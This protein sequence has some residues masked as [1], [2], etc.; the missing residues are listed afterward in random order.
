M[1]KLTAF[2]LAAILLSTVLSAQDSGNNLSTSTPGTSG[3]I[4][5]HPEQGILPFNAPCTDCV[6]LL[7]KRTLNHREFV[8][9]SDGTGERSVFVQQSLGNMHY[10]DENGFL[11]TKDP[12]MKKESEF[13]YA[14]RQQPSPVV[15]D[16]KNK[17]A[18]I[19]NSDKELK[20]N[21]N[22]SLV[23]I[24]LTGETQNF[25][26]G[27]WS[28]VVMSDDHTET[29]LTVK[30]F[31]PGINLVMTAGAGRLKTSFV[32][33]QRLQINQ[34]FSGG[35]LAMTQQLDIPPGLTAD[36]SASI[37]N[38]EHRHL[39][40]L[41]LRDE[42]NNSAFYFTRST[43]YDARESAENFLEMPF[44]FDDRKIEYYVPVNWLNS[45]LTKYPVT[46]DPSVFSGDT[47]LQASIQSSGYSA[48]CGTQGCSYAMN[49]VMVP[50]G[51]TYRIFSYFAYLASLP[52]TRQEG[53]FEITVTNP[54]TGSTCSTGNCS[55]LGSVQGSCAFWPQQL[56]YFGGGSVAPCLSP[57]CSS[58][59]LNFEILLRRCNWVPVPV[60]D[61]TCIQAFTD[62]II[63]IESS[64]AIDISAPP[65]ICSGSCTDI[66]AY[67]LLGVP[68]FTYSWNGGT[69]NGSL[70]N[71]CPTTT[72]TYECIATDICGVNDTD[73]VSIIVVP[74]QNPGFTIGPSDS[75]CAGTQMTFTAN[76]NDPDSLFSWYVE[77]LT[78]DTITDTKVVNYTAPNNPGQCTVT[79]VYAAG[80][81][82]CNLLTDT[83][84]VI[85]TTPS[86]SIVGPDT[87][88]SG[89]TVSYTTSVISGGSLPFYLWYLN[90]VSIPNAISNSYSST[91][92]NGDQLV[93]E[94]TSND[95]CSQGM[96]S[97]DT[98]IVTTFP[99]IIPTVNIS[100]SD[101]T[102]CV[103]DVVTFFAN[104]SGA[105][106]NP[107]YN[108]TL[109]GVS[110]G[111][112]T[113]STYSVSLTSGALIGVSVASNLICVDP[114][115]ASDTIQIVVET[116]LG[117]KELPQSFFSLHPNP[118][119]DLL[120]IE[121]NSSSRNSKSVFIIDALGRTVIELQNVKDA[122]L[123]VDLSNLARATYFVKVVEG[124]KEYMEKLV[125][126]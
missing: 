121:F 82:G 44:T 79:M 1:K 25:G 33:T 81:T 125:V 38:A 101:D 14:A 89:D 100:A 24:S 30:D 32:I 18:S 61:N 37:E 107:E 83:F 58:Y 3:K 102:V 27:N 120:N 104:S 93:V 56:Y 98:I 13:V 92:Q 85:T 66:I 54:G 20:F 64:T 51:G 114:D 47:L 4:K 67:P 29:T 117:I 21:R 36:L 40:R 53:G 39:G 70:I 49:N 57:Q 12:H 75:V 71:V 55:C 10:L 7:E 28:N 78:T 105:G 74:L 69:L 11:I 119:T 124:G 23:L 110:V 48:V 15:I 42:K 94:M 2:F 52:C 34:R 113:S 9:K 35:W 97:Y 126:Q 62:W 95:A 112:V 96:V 88:C 73:S 116:C 41:D 60:C 65:T 111:G 106:V 77:C 115:F 50:P 123:K 59:P 63:N 72:T 19:K 108:W 76:S 31:Y 6:E 87:I 122:A 103:G 8:G 22:I 68:P 84:F 80:V 26:E 90:G 91:F 118:A 5:N 109:N 99:T 46:L 43:A 17:W 86:I 16:F 45:E